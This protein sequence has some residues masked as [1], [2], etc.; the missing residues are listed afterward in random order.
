MLQRQFGVRP[1]ASV[2]K[3]AKLVLEQKTTIASLNQILLT[4]SIQPRSFNDAWPIISDVIHVLGVALRSADIAY[5][6][7][8]GL[9]HVDD[10]FMAINE[11][12]VPAV[13]QKHPRA[14][15]T[16]FHEHLTVNMATVLEQSVTHRSMSSVLEVYHAIT[17]V[18]HALPCGIVDEPATESKLTDACCGDRKVLAE[19]LRDLWLL[20]V[21]KGYVS[22]DILDIK[23]R[24]ILSL[25][26]LL[27]DSYHAY[28]KNGGD[29]HTVLQYLA[30]FLRIGNFT[31][32]I[33]S[34]D[35]HASLVK[36]CSDVV[37]FLAAIGTY[38]DHE[39][40][41]IWQACTTSVEAEFV[42]ASFE[43]LR[44]LLTYARPPQIL[45]M[46]RKYSQTPASA[47]GPFAVHFLSDIFTRFH[48]TNTSADLPLEPMRISFEIMKRCDSDPVAASTSSLRCAAVHEISLLNG[49][50]YVIDERKIL[51]D[52]CLDEM[53]NRTR[54]ATSSMEVLF[55]FM[56]PSNA[57]EVELIL[58]LLPVKAAVDEL[59]H[60]VS[61]STRDQEVGAHTMLEA[62]KVRLQLVLY[63]V[64][65]DG[66][67]EDKE[68]E[69]RLWSCTIGDAAF[70]SQ[71][72]E[73]ALDCFISTP[74]YTRN[75]S[76]VGKL[77]H[78]GVDQ[79]LPT[80]SAD[81]A[82]LGLVA[83]LKGKV[84]E[85]EAVATQDNIE[86]ILEDQSW[87]QLTRLTT[88]TSSDNVATAGISAISDVLFPKSILRD[89]PQAVARQ[90]A[91]VRSHIDFLQDL[92]DEKDVSIRQNSIDRGITLL[93]TVHHHSKAFKPQVVGDVRPIELAGNAE[94]DR[95]EFKVHIHG[96]QGS[97]VERTVKA[98]QDCHIV[99][100]GKALRSTSGVAD[101]DLVLNGS[102][103]RLED[104][105]DQ[106]LH[107]A[108]IK[109]SSVVSIRPRYTF[110][111]DFEKVFASANPV[112]SE[113]RARFQHLESLLDGPEVVAE[114]VG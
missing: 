3:T 112:E 100:L 93:E 77:F 70:S 32:Y 26:Q 66:F 20:Q 51:Y 31:E 13:C 65:L 36:E 17:R 80:M 106:T 29:E 98:L 63:L 30:R 8:D 5:H 34:A 108:G 9:K 6:A 62:V 21:L 59:E 28:H 48:G 99:D 53:K 45:H 101:H 18:D 7:G 82:T 1:M 33:F 60:F 103:S 76:S 81:C 46:A 105:S 67:T 16:G 107:E 91:F 71:A 86:R 2:N 97:P 79:F 19:L 72:R 73:V 38:T 87:Q 40:D 23:S 44:N 64:G 56:K 24:G 14:L 41:L 68:L 61:S 85:A 22:T 35:S 58:D 75:P 90:A 15:P 92:Q 69:E 83:F 78:R 50:A 10:M 96:P 42:K 11:Y 55:L 111:C 49:T 37:G 89:S 104:I 43:V 27:K 114:R 54:H 52:M 88:T 102:L 57:K 109:A 12:V 74:Q 4:L 95:I 39:T 94:S 110:D 113:I 84:K 47:L 25:R